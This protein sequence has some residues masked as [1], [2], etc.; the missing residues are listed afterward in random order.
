MYVANH[1]IASGTNAD[2]VGDISGKNKLPVIPDHFDLEWAVNGLILHQSSQSNI[3]ACH[4]RRCRCA[5][6]TGRSLEPISFDKGYAGASLAETH[7]NVENGP[8]TDDACHIFMGRSLSEPFD[9]DGT[10]FDLF[11]MRPVRS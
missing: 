3:P 4:S 1:E 2:F 5:V 9:E 8:T 7:V 10:L 11:V 6:S